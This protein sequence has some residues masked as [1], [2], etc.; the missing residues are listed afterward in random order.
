[1]SNNGQG[2]PKVYTIKVVEIDRENNKWYTAH[3]D[4]IEA[5][6]PPLT[7]N[8]QDRE[9]VL[10]AAVKP[11]VGIICYYH[12]EGSRFFVV[13]DPMIWAEISKLI[14]IMAGGKDEVH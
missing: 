3:T 7:W 5:V 14:T 11:D 9:Y 4:T 2:K 10:K 13:R 8:W 6:S 1:M 12:R